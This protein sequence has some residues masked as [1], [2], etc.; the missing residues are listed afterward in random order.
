[1][2][3]KTS[4][5]IT[6]IKELAQACAPNAEQNVDNVNGENAQAESASVDSKAAKLPKMPMPL[7]RLEFISGLV[8]SFSNDGKHAD[9]FGGHFLTIDK[10]RRVEFW[11]DKIYSFVENCGIWGLIVDTDGKTRTTTAIIPYNGKNVA[12]TMPHNTGKKPIAEL[13]AAKFQ[14][15]DIYGYKSDYLRKINSYIRDE[16]ALVAIITFNHMIDNNFSFPAA[17]YTR[18]DMSLLKR[19]FPAVLKYFEAGIDTKADIKLDYR[20]IKS[21]FDYRAKLKDIILD[22]DKSNNQKTAAKELLAKIGA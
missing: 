22:G 12:I 6:N 19:E 18:S 9:K 14:G 3:K 15:E 21:Y 2:A 4:D 16:K 10:M 11:G 7:D 13:V 5:K 8:N 17:F 1:M 20:E